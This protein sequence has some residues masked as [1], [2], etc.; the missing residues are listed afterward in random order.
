MNQK[1]IDHLEL[2]NILQMDNFQL[3][4]QL[5]GLNFHNY[6]RFEKHNML[7]LKLKQLMM[8]KHTFV[9]IVLEMVQT[10]YFC[11]IQMG[12]CHYTGIF[13]NTII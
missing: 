12:K 11:F 5:N 7:Y 13:N 1:A 9:E 3:Q 10:V 4:L 2:I 8:V 6:F